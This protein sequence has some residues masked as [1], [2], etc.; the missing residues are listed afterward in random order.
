VDEFHRQID[1]LIQDLIQDL[2]RGSG[3]SGSHRI[4][5]LG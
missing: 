5:Q 1:A 2:E 4:R 3:P